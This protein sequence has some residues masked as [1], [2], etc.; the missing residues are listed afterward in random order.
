[1]FYAQQYDEAPSDFSPIGSIC[2]KAGATYPL[3]Y[4]TH[5]AKVKILSLAR[6]LCALQP[7]AERK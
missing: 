2:R 4:Y 7:L 3:N 1:M 6:A 5:V